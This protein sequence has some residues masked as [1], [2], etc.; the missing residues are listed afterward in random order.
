MDRQIYRAPSIPKIN[1]KNI[2]SPFGRGGAFSPGK[3]QLKRSTFSFSK[4]NIGG[5]INFENL[6]PPKESAE[7]QIGRNNSIGRELEETNRIL[8]EIQKQ[9]SLDF[10]YRIAEEKKAFALEKKKISARR[11]EDK[12]SRI[13]KGPQ[14]ILG[15]TF[16][17]VTAPFRSIFDKLIEFFS[18]ILTGILLN[19][20]FNWLADKKNQAKVT[21]FFTFIADYWK[22]LLIIFAAYKLLKL[23]TAIVGVVGTLRKLLEWFKGFKPPKPLI[24]TK[25]PKNPKIKPPTIRNPS[26]GLQRGPGSAPTP[27]PSPP[28]PLLGP[29]GNPLSSSPLSRYKG[30]GAVPGRAPGI[31]RPGQGI[32]PKPVESIPKSGFK[33]PGGNLL[34]NVGWLKNTSGLLFKNIGGILRAVGAYFLFEELK[35]DYEKGDFK[36]ITV[37]LSAYG[38]GW[39][40]SSIVGTAIAGASVFAV[41]ET[42][43]TSLAGLALAGTAAVGTQMGTEYGIRNI[44]GYKDGGTIG[45]ES[46]NKIKFSEGGTVGKG[47]RPGIDTVPAGNK[48]L[49]QGEEVVKTSS[50]MLFRPLLKDINE[51][52][53]RLWQ[54]FTQG[55]I[56]LI[57]ITGVQEQNAKLFEKIIKNYDKFLTDQIRK[58]K[59]KESETPPAGGGVPHT[60][61]LPS[62]NAIGGEAKSQPTTLNINMGKSGGL[63]TPT[64]PSSSSGSV[65]PTPTLPI[66][67]L[68]NIVNNIFNAPPQINNAPNISSP[69]LEKSYLIPIK[70]EVNLQIESVKSNGRGGATVLPPITIPSKPPKIPTYPGKSNQIPNIIPFDP[71]NSWLSK[72]SIS[73]RYCIEYGM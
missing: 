37:K 13:E 5:G 46:D 12:E 20:A 34:K 32:T 3:I 29:T 45:D 69:N 1:R 18:I 48:F 52:A 9:L 36:A 11:A 60:S 27:R 58:L 33:F 21:A 63:T 39:L 54:Q 43:G 41:P 42:G 4:L 73:S 17:A 71:L 15:K 6:L 55:I 61:S 68:N 67:P 10:A 65:T 64:T 2:A 16:A 70:T 22:E 57:N 44:F 47:D 49:N 72:D 38:L 62:K 26:P 8:V 31:P 66:V 28:R 19:N 59:L 35:K 24:P 23:I 53:G 56:K 14:S 51:N 30:P 50:A 25:V 40:A 7:S